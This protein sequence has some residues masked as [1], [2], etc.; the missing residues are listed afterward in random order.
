MIKVNGEEEWEVEKILAIHMH[1]WKLQYKIKWVGY[2]DNPEW[3]D[4]RNM[5]FSPYLP[6]DFHKKYLDRSRPP[7]KTT[8]KSAGKAKMLKIGQIMT[9][10]FRRNVPRELMKPRKPPKKTINN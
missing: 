5:K 1:R 9:D 3:Y 7:K 6:R 10:L 8:G 2:D 4:A